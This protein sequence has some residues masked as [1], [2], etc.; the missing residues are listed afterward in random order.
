MPLMT[1]NVKKMDSSGSETFCFVKL[2]MSPPSTLDILNSH[3]KTLKNL[4]G[5]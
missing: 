4:S 1:F 3:F 2:V 5:R